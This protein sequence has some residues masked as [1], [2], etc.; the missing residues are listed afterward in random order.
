MTRLS[1]A[2]AEAA[3]RAAAQ[4][5]VSEQAR[6]SGGF[7]R[8]YKQAGGNL[9]DIGHHKSGQSWKDRREGFLARHTAQMDGSGWEHVSGADRPTRRHLA[10]AVWAHS[11]TPGRLRTWL[12][13]EGFMET[14]GRISNGRSCILAVDEGPSGAAVLLSPDASRV[15]GAWGW[16]WEGR[17]KGGRMLTG[18]RTFASLGAIGEHVAERVDALAEGPVDM[19]V[20]AAW[21]RGTDKNA[22]GVARALRAAVQ[23]S[24]TVDKRT[25]AADLLGV[26]AAELR[27]EQQMYRRMEALVSDPSLPRLP[28]AL[29]RHR[30]T[31]DAYAVALWAA[32]YRAT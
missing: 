21:G 6:G 26:D 5:G 7:L 24:A 28:K 17:S 11:P 4:R 18:G 12:Q 13:Q 23:S 19:T 30:H 8:A 14:T 20:E 10:L 22:R 16:A 15:L 3:G 32:G 25:W 27:R 1:L 9:S 31:W 29:R 2:V